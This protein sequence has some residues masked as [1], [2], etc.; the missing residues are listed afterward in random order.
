M[1]TTVLR[2]AAVISMAAL[3]A[4]QPTIL[5]LAQVSGPPAQDP[6]W[7]RQIVKNGTTLVYYQ[8]QIDAWDNYKDLKGRAAFTLTPQNGK[9][10]AGVV[11]F[12]SGTTVD[13]D[14]RTVY[15]HDLKYT[16]V[17]F[18]SLDAQAAGQMEQTFRF[19]AP[20]QLEPIALDRL[21]AEVDRSKAP[22]PAPPL[23][24]DP[25]Q[26]FYSNTP[27]ILLIVQGQ[28]VLSP[29]EK[30]DLQFLVNANWDVFFD[31]SKKQYYLLA[32]NVW[33]TAA[34]LDGAWTLAKTLPKD[35]TKL[36]AGENW[37]QVKKMVP[38]PPPSGTVPR[39]FYSVT[40]AELLLV[41]G[42]PVY[43]RISGTQ[44]LY[45]T[46]T[47][48]DLF[49]ND[50]EKQFYVLVS[51]RW[52]R[53]KQPD[54]PWSYAGNDLPKDFAKIPE[55]SLKAHV[56]ASVPGTIDA[57]DAILLA[58]IPTTATINKS[59][60]EAS[61]KVSYNGPQQFQPIPNTSLQYAANTQ[62]EVIKD[63]NQYYLC[64]QGVWF[65]SSSP[66]GPWKT[67]DSVPKEIYSIPPSSPVYNV[68]YVTQTSTSADTAVSST[69]G[70]YFGMFVL[71]A[72][73]GAAIC[74]GTGYYYPPYFY[75]GP[76]FPY[77]YYRPW[78]ITYGAGVAYNPWTGGWAAGRA[79]YGP[80]AAAGSA[81]WYNPA[82]GRYGHA[83]SV[84]GWYNGRT[85]ASAYNPWTGGRAVTT[86]GHDPYAQWGS[87]VATRNGQAIQTG[88]IITANGAAA[89]YRTSTGQHGG[90]ITGPNGTIVKGP[91]ST[92][93]GNDGNVYRKD[94]SGNW[95]KYDNG[96]WSPVDTSQAKQ[97][98]E[99]AHPNAQ[100][101]I[102]NAQDAR[103]TRQAGSGNRLGATQSIQPQ[104]LDGL[105]RSAQARQRG[106]MQTQRFQNFHRRNFGGF[107][108]R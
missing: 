100:Q 7:P 48:S 81:A 77:P 32:S 10:A 94:S 29:I 83:A 64:F 33:L 60:A 62:N 26:I 91:N 38:P 44:L 20:T 17:R 50:A 42:Q 67:A 8:P 103:A 6:G 97:N 51:G 107:R 5:A 87:T 92:Y 99:N 80:Y 74:Y 54:G 9:Q 39:V 45:V 98:F 76:G 24:T 49:L 102:H 65:V 15:L 25:P 55:G 89:G 27:A 93:A 18:P 78:P 3:I 40:P 46:N 23:K 106:Q 36:P 71:G 96:N 47:D 22:V 105:N 70:G 88:H 2:A 58:Q 90:V 4:V 68:T 28:P 31:K 79:V 73:V 56:L 11:S 19:V 85:V 21:M 41:K 1:K 63:G 59:Q 82:T 69:T 84:Q 66:T 53:A 108:R 72:A 104:T 86:Q 37:D 13:K 14:N 75:W 52:F 16:S 101:D 61:V 35:M 12:D 43:T 95:S 34:T 30:T 57:S